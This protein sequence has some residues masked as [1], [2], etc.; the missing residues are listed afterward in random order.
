MAAFAAVIFAHDDGALLARVLAQ[1][2]GIGGPGKNPPVRP[3]GGVHLAAARRADRSGVVP[4]QAVQGHQARPDQVLPI[5]QQVV[6]LQAA[7]AALAPAD[8]NLD[9]Q[10]GVVVGVARIVEV[11]VILENTRQLKRQ[12]ARTVGWNR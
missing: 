3:V 7:R 5:E 12:A 10:V 11:V 6:N 4:H 1:V 9:L 2:E 8:I